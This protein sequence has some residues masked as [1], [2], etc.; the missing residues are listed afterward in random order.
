M[1][2]EEQTKPTGELSEAHRV[3]V[4]GMADL[5]TEMGTKFASIKTYEDFQVVKDACETLMDKYEKEHT[6]LN[7]LF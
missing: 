5:F 3:D 6:A 2:T 4:Q 7:E 1:T